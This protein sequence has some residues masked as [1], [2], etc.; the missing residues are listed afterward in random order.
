MNICSGLCSNI[1]G[2]NY[3][4]VI[5]F[6]L[7]SFSIRTVESEDFE[8]IIE[9]KLLGGSYIESSDD[10]K[11]QITVLKVLYF[12]YMKNNKMK[13]QMK[14]FEIFAYNHFDEDTIQKLNGLIHTCRNTKIYINKINGLLFLN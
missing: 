3:R 8:R 7:N 5:Q 10:N 14:V 6:D 4:I 2:C 12:E 11:N 13:K 1:F 9:Y